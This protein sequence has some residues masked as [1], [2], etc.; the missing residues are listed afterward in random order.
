MTEEEHEDD[1]Y[2]D[3]S[4]T[5]LFLMA[6]NLIPATENHFYHFIMNHNDDSLTS[7]QKQPDFLLSQIKTGDK[8]FS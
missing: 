3:Y 4:E 7:K 6:M 2:Q 1:R 5:F 8:T